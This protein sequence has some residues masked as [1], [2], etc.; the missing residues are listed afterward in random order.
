[1]CA[2]N[3]AP[4][5]LCPDFPGFTGLQAFG[6]GIPSTLVQGIG[7]PKTVSPT[8]RWACF[9]QDS[10]RVRSNLTF[11]LG[12]RYDVEFPPKFTQPDA[13]ALAAYNRL[14]LQKGIQTD[15]NNYSASYRPGLGP[16]G[17]RQKC[18]SRI[19]WIFY[20]HPLLGLYFL[21]TPPTDRRAGNCFSPVAV[22]AILV[23]LPALA[24]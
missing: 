18:S 23:L 16:E 5:A 4:A 14:G 19:V 12:V 22:P 9:W 13:L 6:L 1:L 24:V 7:N 2:A 10:F 20:D 3:S 11:N 15:S 8:S 17:G 21:A